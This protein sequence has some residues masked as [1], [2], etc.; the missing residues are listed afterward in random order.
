MK[1]GLL[2]R[3]HILLLLPFV[4]LLSAEPIF[5]QTAPEAASSEGEKFQARIN[6]A[7]RTL[8]NNPRFKSLS[9]KNRQELA[10]FITGNMLFVLLHEIGHA[11]ITQMGLPVLGRPEDAADSFAAVGLIRIGSEF[12][13]R[14][15]AEAAKGWF[16]ADRRDDS[17]G[18]T[19][20]FY[21]EH[22]L[23]QQ[24]AYQIVCLMVGSD[25]D[26]FKDVA[27]D[28][29]LPKARQESCAGDFSNAAFSWDLLLK[30]H[31]RAPDQ[32]KTKIDVIYGEAKGRVEFAAQALRSIQ[33]LET[34]A[35][36]TAEAFAWPVP[37]TLELQSC[38]F[39]NAGWD[40][41]THK[42]TLCYELAA[43]FA[44]LYTAYGAAPAQARR[45]A[46]PSQPRKRKSK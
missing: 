38:G 33:L 43:D 31:V 13:H 21:D 18:D 23:N 37:F 34:V 46:R 44:E 41:S 5:A 1:P 16:L 25:E 32:P 20:A 22:G 7:A 35:E 26:K 27:A 40:L 36:H 10:E 14:V 19:V 6:D 30:P 9:P 29:K 8:G 17:T 4:L 11:T 45:S 28:T 3:R 39:P 2:Q 24:R 42:L 12:S 15:L